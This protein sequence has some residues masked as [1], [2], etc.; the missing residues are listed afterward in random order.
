VPLDDLRQR[1]DH[2]Q[3]THPRV[4]QDRARGVAQAEPAH[5]DIERVVVQGGQAEPGE[6]DLG[7]GE[8]A[9]HQEVVAQLDLV[10][11]RAEDRLAPPAQSQVTERGGPPVELF[12]CDAHRVLL[13]AVTADAALGRL[14][15]RVA[16]G[17]VRT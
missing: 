15:V 17:I 12:E 13:R 4:L 16:R 7:L 11:V 14:A 8:Q 3:G 5:G 2:H 9:G 10:D 6:L 1:V